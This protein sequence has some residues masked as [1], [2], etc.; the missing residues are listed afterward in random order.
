MR[1]EIENLTKTF[2]GGAAAA[3]NGVEMTVADGELVALLGPSGSG[4]TTLLRLI[5]GLEVPDCGRI[6][7]DG[8]D[9]AN[10]DVRKRNVGFV[11][12][13]YAL[14]KTMTVLSNVAFG[15]S[16]RPR[17]TR[18]PRREIEA[19][20]RELIRLVQLD[21]LESRYPAQLSGGQRQRVALARALAIDPAALLLDEPFGALDAKVRKELRGWLRD[22]HDRTGHTT[23]FV[24][25]DQEEALEL[26][27]RVA[28]LNAGR[29]A[30]MAP[31]VALYRAPADPFVCEFLGSAH[32]FEVEAAGGRALWRGH[33]LPLPQPLE[34]P[35]GPRL[36]YVRAHEFRIL[37]ADS[38]AAIP[39]TVAA[40]RPAGPLVRLDLSP[41]WGGDAIE[42]EMPLADFAASGWQPGAAVGLRIGNCLVY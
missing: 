33:E 11:F 8:A 3:L 35:D 10:L 29:I 27:D 36:L 32:R 16:V 26:A 4:K 20:A 31:P 39:C 25:H 22:L 14:F 30:Q 41:A 15:L 21:G 42:A 17:E 38:P 2:A 1:I 5:A 19:R 24:T 40:V 9:I 6:L 7:F 18:P 12:Q 23:L 37:P 34:G 13:H 28:V